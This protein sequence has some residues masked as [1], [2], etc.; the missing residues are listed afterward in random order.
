MKMAGKYQKKNFS[1]Y[2]CAHLRA[3]TPENI[4]AAF[5]KMGVYPY[6]PSVI[7]KD[8]LVPAHETAI[9]HHAIIPTMETPVQVLVDAF[10]KLE[11]LWHAEVTND[12]PDGE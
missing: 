6:D 11:W 1:V 7:T 4:K 2:S 5:R 3:L 12:G 9:K 10:A 8:L